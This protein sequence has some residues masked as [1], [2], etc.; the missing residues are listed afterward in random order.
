MYSDDVYVGKVANKVLEQFPLK[1]E[2]QKI[3]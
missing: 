3:V 1:D 2:F